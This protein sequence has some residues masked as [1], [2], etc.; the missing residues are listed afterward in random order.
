MKKEEYK[1]LMELIEA[2][3]ATMLPGNDIVEVSRFRDLEAVFMNTFIFEKD[4]LNTFI[5]PKLPAR[6]NPFQVALDERNE[7]SS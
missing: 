4:Y 7:L 2:K 5:I 6:P 1:S 3:I